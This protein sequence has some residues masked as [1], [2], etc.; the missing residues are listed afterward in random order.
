[1]SHTSQHSPSI[2]SESTLRLLVRAG[3]ALA[4]IVSLLAF[5]VRAQAQ[6]Q[7]PMGSLPATAS[8]VR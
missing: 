2:P 6:A 4:V 1:M 3:I 5:A 7:M 8:A